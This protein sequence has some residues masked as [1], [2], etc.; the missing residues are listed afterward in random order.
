MVPKIAEQAD[1]MIRAVQN[2]TPQT[3]VIDEIGR[4]QEARA[5]HTIKTRGVRMIASAHGCFRD[6]M[7]NPELKQLLG[8]FQTVILPGSGRKS[9]KTTVERCGTPVF[10]TIVEIVSHN[11]FRII[12]DVE[13]AVDLALEGKQFQVQERG[14]EGEPV[15]G[16]YPYMTL[17]LKYA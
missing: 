7:R 8:G 15:E 17:S 1:L 4:K 11:C 6:L 5:A 3:M 13:A 16:M 12:S 9:K 10:D 14:F 2:H